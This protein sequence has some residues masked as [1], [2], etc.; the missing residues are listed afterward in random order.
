MRIVIRVTATIVLIFTAFMILPLIVAFVY[1]ESLAPFLLPMIVVIPSIIVLLFFLQKVKDYLPVR[2]SFVVVVFSWLIS[3][4]IGALPFIYAQV[5]PTWVDAI[6]ETMSGLTTT[7]ASILSDIE[8]LPKSLLF[9]RSC[10]HWLGGMGIIVLTVAILPLLGVGGVKLLQAEA[11]GP[12]L[13]KITPTI[14]KAAKI[15]WMTYVL[16]TVLETLML[17]MGGM[18]FFDALTHTFGTVATGGFSP[19]NAS[20]GYYHSAYIEWVIILFMLL[21]GINFVLYFRLVSRDFR[22]VFE[23]VE[24]RVYIAVFFF[25]SLIIGLNLW[26]SGRGVSDSFRSAAFHGA[27]ILT[28]TGFATEDF[29]Q[30]PKLSQ[31]VL[32]ALMFVGG[33]AG[34]TGGGIKVIRIVILAKQAL[35]SLYSLLSPRAVYQLR[36]GKIPIEADIQRNVSGFLFLYLLIVLITTVIMSSGGNDLFTSFSG[37]LAI[38]GNI[39]PGFGKLGPALNYGALSLPIKGY[40]S[41][42]MMLGRL[43]LF[44]VLV[45]FVPRTKRG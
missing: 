25:A 10:T 13:D 41:F 20:V 30:W 12:S 38:L 21:A 37:S 9:W 16:F 15:L 1:H 35:H 36:A 2:H 31:A 14:G 27:S 24:F 23:D 32:L 43:E 39:G 3:A 4:V 29:L 26:Y 44:T 6:F 33:S 5:M 45:L 11:P 34:S 22:S 17:R 42:V 7:G 40:L 28:T 8:A 19:K 18:S